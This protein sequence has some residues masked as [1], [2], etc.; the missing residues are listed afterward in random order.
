MTPGGTCGHTTAEGFTDH[1]YLYGTRDG[2][3]T[4][5]PLIGAP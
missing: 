1:N 2:G 4:W 5:T 3:L